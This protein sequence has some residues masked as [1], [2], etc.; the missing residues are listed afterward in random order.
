[1]KPSQINEVEEGIRLLV[2]AADKL[3]SASGVYSNY[4]QW[5]YELVDS[6]QE[7]LDQET[8]Q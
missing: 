3:Y 2:E 4:G 1:M 7:Q 6:I 8:V 5:I